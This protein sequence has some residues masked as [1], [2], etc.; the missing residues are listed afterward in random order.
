MEE[1]LGTPP[2]AHFSTGT[3]NPVGKSCRTRFSRN[4]NGY[5]SFL[6]V[7]TTSWSQAIFLPHY[8]F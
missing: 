4:S 7:G 5:R 3:P 6:W 8:L 1:F 2:S